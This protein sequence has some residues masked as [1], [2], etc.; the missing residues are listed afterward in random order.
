MLYERAVTFV[1]KFML[2][3]KTE[4]ISHGITLMGREQKSTS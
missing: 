1:K 4:N 2:N 3:L